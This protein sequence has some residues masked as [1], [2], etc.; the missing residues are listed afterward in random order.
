MRNL[1]RYCIDMAKRIKIALE[2]PTQHLP[3]LTSLTDFDF[4][5]AHEILHNDTYRRFY[6]DQRTRYPERECFLDNGM[7]ESGGQSPLTLEDLC[8]A[9]GMIE[10]T[11]VIVPDVLHVRVQTI[12]NAKEWCEMQKWHP[13]LSEYSFQFVVQGY[14]IADATECYKELL[15]L[16]IKQNEEVTLPNGKSAVMTLS[17]PLGIGACNLDKS[18]WAEIRRDFVW[19]LIEKSWY[20]GKIKVH[21]MSI[22]DPAELYEYTKYVKFHGH[23]FPIS[24]LDTGAPI[25]AAKAGIKYD[26]EGHGERVWEVLNPTD[27]LTDEQL[28]LARY[29]INMLRRYAIA[30]S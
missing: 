9:I 24:S 3:E 5:L 20:H 28:A 15:D 29:N 18:E 22:V 26:D 21:L 27:I 6:V 4:A 13:I 10:P 23:N 19:G 7:W 17:I 11:E 8:V 14:D 12:K 2:I 1:W 30:S 25:R 16:A